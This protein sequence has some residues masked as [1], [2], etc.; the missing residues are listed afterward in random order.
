MAQAKG[1]GAAG[2]GR[3]VRK[4]M[5]SQPLPSNTALMF[6]PHP[7]A[8]VRNELQSHNFLSFRASPGGGSL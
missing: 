5:I 6:K 4:N 1:F 3:Q 8:W 7:A 2:A